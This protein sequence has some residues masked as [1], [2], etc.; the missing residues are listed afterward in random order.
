MAQLPQFSETTKPDLTD[1]EIRERVDLAISAHVADLVK[2]REVVRPGR[3]LGRAI[4]EGITEIIFKV[5]V[6][7][8]YVRFPQGHGSL[9]VH[10]L[11][12]NAQ[13]KRLPTGKMVTMSPNRVRVKYEEGAAVREALGMPRKTSYVR[14]FDRESALSDRVIRILDN[15]SAKNE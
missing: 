1:E 5:A 13:P 2:D 7:Y 11:K 8:G 12:R 10:R 4:F 3:E 9:K 15:G 6:E 14:Q